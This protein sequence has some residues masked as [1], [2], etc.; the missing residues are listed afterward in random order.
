MSELSMLRKSVS[1]AC[2]HS[3]NQ[4]F[5][6]NCKQY[7]LHVRLIFLC[8]REWSKFNLN[9]FICIVYVYAH[10]CVSV[11]VRVCVFVFAGTFILV[12]KEHFALS[13]TPPTNTK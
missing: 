7:K 13:T 9:Q 10:V 2:K 4:C 5:S 3:S 6:L 12:F 11:G 8:W 1:S